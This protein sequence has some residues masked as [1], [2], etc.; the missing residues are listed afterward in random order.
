MNP[1]LFM[2]ARE[3]RFNRQK[4]GGGLQSGTQEKREGQATGM[5]DFPL[6][7][8]APLREPYFPFP[9]SG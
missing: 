3:S 5:M 8:F 2:G 1:M 9:S 6:C 7:V 4:A